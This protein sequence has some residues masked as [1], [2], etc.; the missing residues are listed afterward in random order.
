M[1]MVQIKSMMMK[2]TM[3]AADLLEDIDLEAV[4]VAAKKQ[5]VDPGEYELYVGY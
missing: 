5:S 2:M 3:S 1:T 4:L